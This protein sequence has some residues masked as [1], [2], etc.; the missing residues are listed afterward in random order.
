[1][2]IR[3]TTLL[4]ILLCVLASSHISHSFRKVQAGY[5]SP[6]LS[7]D[8]NTAYKMMTNGSFLNLV[9][10]DVRSQGEYDE[11]H[12]YHAVL[13]P[14]TELE[15]RIDELAT[16]THH[17]II[18]Y[19]RTG[20]RS[21]IASEILDTYGFA[22]V[23]NMLG[24]IQT[25]TAE[26]YPVRLS[27]VHNLETSLDYDDIQTAIDAAETMTG[28]TI[29]IDAGTYY[30]HIEV[31]KSLTLVGEDRATTIIDGDGGGMVVK[32]TVDKVRLEGLTV[33]SG[34]WG[35]FITESDF[36]VITGNIIRDNQYGIYLLAVCQC[37]PSSNNTIIN[38][39]IQDNEVGIYLDVS[40][41]NT[42]YHNNFI[43]NTIHADIGVGEVNTWDN[44]YPSGGN[45]WSSSNTVDLVK[46]Q[47]RNESGE[48]GLGDNP[49]NIKGAGNQD[50]YPLM[51]NHSRFE[52]ALSL[53]IHIIANSTIDVFRYFESN[54]TI[55]LWV[56]NT[57]ASQAFGFLR[58]QIPHVLMNLDKVWVV[59]DDS[60]TDVLH[61]NLE[62]HD[63]TTHRWIYFAYTHSS[64]QVTIGEDESPPMITD[65]SQHPAN[66]SVYSD[67]S[68]EVQ[69]V[70]TDHLSGVKH[71]ILTYTINGT[72]KFPVNMT[73]QD[74]SIYKAAIPEFPAGTDV[75]FILTAEDYADNIITTEKEYHYQVIRE[76]QP[77]DML[78]PIA[79]L[80]TLIV[81]SGGVIWA[82]FRK[83]RELN[84]PSK[85]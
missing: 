51:G 83:T 34:S 17:P 9:I 38:N 70:I 57:T 16:H 42:I 41:Y 8:V 54:S 2:R 7:V 72:T 50:H 1:M 62:L 64:R 37:D 27:T 25:W 43:D 18:V 56:S 30:E 73:R 24:G 45:Y 39:I 35:I 13:I 11:G 80:V 48:D 79:A 21:V 71:A 5:A 67:S 65:V 20:V 26:G 77:P 4:V 84:Q 28:H 74:G 46:G 10:L 29:A 55:R 76:A 85:R 3:T 36:T 63:N 15:T 23:F 12:I 47:D 22:T 59:I 60:Q 78:T 49:F 31:H 66:T 52:T 53:S 33:Q 19:C 61:P 44:G 32:V 68:V 40:D 82:Y 75:T 58:A 6:Y 69:T 14:H 81:I